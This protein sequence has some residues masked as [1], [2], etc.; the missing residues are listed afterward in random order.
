MMI[1]TACGGSEPPGETNQPAVAT[2]AT[3][4]QMMV[5]S[6]PTEAP[7]PEPAPPTPTQLP[8]LSPTLPPT[9]APTETAPAD[10]SGNPD[11]DYAQ[12]QFVRA[13]QDS[14]GLWT[15][16]TTVRHNDE[17]WDHY[18][19]AWQ[20]VDLDGN[21][22]AERILTHPHD[23]EQP[24]TR[25]QSNINIPPDTIQVIVRAKCNG[26]GFGGQEVLVD[27]TAAEGKNFE[28]SR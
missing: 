13:T 28:L 11:L 9:I 3:P 26:H 18:A 22:L 20:V 16:N 23:N 25:N 4:T 10:L 12:V 8:E 2:A 24:F 21:L 6:T 5:P 1:L 15:F 7:T 19:N 17:G 14:D 27:L